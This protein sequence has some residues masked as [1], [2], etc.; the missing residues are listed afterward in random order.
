MYTHCAFFSMSPLTSFDKFCLPTDT[1]PLWGGC[2][3]R[4]IN[5]GP[6]TAPLLPQLAPTRDH[7]VLF[8]PQVEASRVPT[9]FPSRFR[10]VWD[11][12]HVKL[13]CSK[14]SLYPVETA[15][16]SGKSLQP[17]WEL[18]LQS[19]RA[20]IQNSYEFERAVMQYNSRYS[21]RWK[22][23][24][25]HAYFKQLSTQ[26]ESLFFEETLPR[27]I[28]LALE[29][30]QVVTHAVPLLRKQEQYSISMSQQQVACLLAN[31]FLC[32]YPRRNATS[33]T[34]EYSSYPSINFNTV[35]TCDEPG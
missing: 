23:D 10:D 15:G 12:N 34:S 27:I 11:S 5:F 17:R 25:L 20:P 26:E 3:L 9:P 30:P 4:D 33:S 18:I 21:T 16:T 13:P 6:S 29:L 7:A 14:Q 22:F 24:G 31:A 32:T 1:I 28:K 2:P 19:L 8:Q 35:F